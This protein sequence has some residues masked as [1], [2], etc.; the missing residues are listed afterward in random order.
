MKYESNSP[1][2]SKDIAQKLE[3]CYKLLL[4]KIGFP[5]L[6]DLTPLSPLQIFKRL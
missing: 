3:L 1:M 5:M 6:S 2:Y 4:G